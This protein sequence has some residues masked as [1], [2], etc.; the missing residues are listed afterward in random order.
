MLKRIRL[1]GVPGYLTTMAATLAL[2]MMFFLPTRVRNESAL[3]IRASHQGTALP[4]GFFV[5]QRLSARGI[6][7]KSITLDNKILIIQFDSFKQS[8]EAE[9]VLR[10]LLPF[11]FDVAQQEEPSP[12]SW[13]SCLNTASQTLS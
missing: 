8:A 4:D 11:D 10:D 7:I 5:Y 2:L 9:K 3:H 12:F 1:Y 6:Q 13:I